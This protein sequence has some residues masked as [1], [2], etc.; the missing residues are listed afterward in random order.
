MNVHRTQIIIEG[1]NYETFF[2]QVNIETKS[3]A[4]A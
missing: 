2:E 1:F 4:H 3:I